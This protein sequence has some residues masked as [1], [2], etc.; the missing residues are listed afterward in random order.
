MSTAVGWSALW[1]FMWVS[2][3]FV[4]CADLANSD[5][6]N[7]HPPNLVAASFP[8]QGT[9]LP[10]SDEPAALPVHLGIGAVT[11]QPD[12]DV[13]RDEPVLPAIPIG[14][15]DECALVEEC[16]NEYLWSIYDR[17]RKIDTIRVSER[18]SWTVKKKKKVR[19]FSKI[20]TKLVNEDFTWKDPKAAEKFGMTVANYVIGGMDR[21]FKVKLY[22]LMRALD[23]AGFEPGITSGFRDD[24]RQ[25]I[26]SGTKA[27]SDRSYHGGSLRGGYGRGLA[28]DVVSVKG[29]TRAE[30]WVSSANLWKWIDAKGEQFGIGRPYLD[31][32]APHVGPTDGEE[33]VR[34][35]GTRRV[36]LEAK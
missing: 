2:L 11:P 25:A 14:A 7:D 28:A 29:E 17:T 32:D 9:A 34:H 4:V 33:Y 5:Q 18:I 8:G 1:R 36:A 10:A 23:E 24:Y 27:A 6:N 21:D 12:T 15:F 3:L 30:R 16:L 22:H 35:R 20:I 31:R 26:A 19:T 13:G